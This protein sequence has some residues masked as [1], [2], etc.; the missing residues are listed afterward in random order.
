[1]STGGTCGLAGAADTVV[2]DVGLGALADNGG[3]TATHLPVA[4]SPAVDRVAIGTAGLCD[5]TVPT[6]QRGVARPS[7]AG[8]DAGAVER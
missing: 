6:D 8:C 5:G 4:G 7:G 1:M 3:P 2:A